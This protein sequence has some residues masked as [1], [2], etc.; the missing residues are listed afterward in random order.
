MSPL[1]YWKQGV[2]VPFCG[3][4]VRGAVGVLFARKYHQQ[5]MC[6]ALTDLVV[7]WCLRGFMV[8]LQIGSV[9]QARKVTQSAC[10]KAPCSVVC[11]LQLLRLRLLPGA[12]WD[13][14]VNLLCV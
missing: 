8:A 5:G 7:L 14:V 11:A 12:T 1:V 4:I 13:Q 9:L 2:T 10:S 3:S 6:V